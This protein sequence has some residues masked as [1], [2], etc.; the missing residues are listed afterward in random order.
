MEGMAS[1]IKSLSLFSRILKENCV[2]VTDCVGRDSNQ[3]SDCHAFFLSLTLSL[4]CKDKILKIKM[5]IQ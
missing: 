5:S 2:C 1:P 3:V 4:A